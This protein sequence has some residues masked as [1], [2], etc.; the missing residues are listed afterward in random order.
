M[1]ANPFELTWS[2]TNVS[3]VFFFFAD[4][5]PLESNSLSHCQWLYDTFSHHGLAQSWCFTL[6]QKEVP[7]FIKFLTSGE[8]KGLSKRLLGMFT[9]LAMYDEETKSLPPPEPLV[10]R[11]M[12]C[13]GMPKEICPLPQTVLIHPAIDYLVALAIEADVV[14]DDEIMRRPVFRVHGDCEECQRLLKE[15]PANHPVVLDK[16]EVIDVL[17]PVKWSEPVDYNDYEDNP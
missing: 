5:F 8:T 11:A 14:P 17:M 9:Y 12:I 15:Y 2:W 3:F 13:T 4:W 1:W 10:L 16:T 7:A 6:M